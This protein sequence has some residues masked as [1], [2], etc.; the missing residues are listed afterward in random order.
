M[1]VSI[2]SISQIH[3]QRLVDESSE[4]SAQECI[5]NNGCDSYCKLIVLPSSLVVNIST[6]EPHFRVCC[7][8][9][10]VCSAKA[11]SMPLV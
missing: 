9:A 1:A 10:V 8:L 11:P 2:Y 6:T 5:A 7:L 3:M 4:R